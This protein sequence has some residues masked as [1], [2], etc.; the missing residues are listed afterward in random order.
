MRR[1]TSLPSDV[2]IANLTED[3]LAELEQALKI[4]EALSGPLPYMLAATSSAKSH[5]HLEYLNDIIV[6]AVELRLY[7]DG[8]GP[9]SVQNSEGLWVHPERG[10]EVIR[11]IEIDEP[12]RHGKSY[13]VSK[14]VP[15][16]FRTVYPERNVV[17]TSYEADFA[18]NWGVEAQQVIRDN[19]QFGAEIDRKHEAADDWKLKGHSGRMFTAGVGGPLTG[20]GF[21]LGIIDDPI[22]NQ[23]E[24]MSETIRTRHKNWWATTFFT[25]REPGAVIVIM[26]TRWHEDDL[27]GHIMETMPGKVFSVSIP[28]LA[29]DTTD[30]EGFSVDP[31]TGVRDILGRKPGEALWPQRFSAADL[32]AIK[33]AQGTLWFTAMYQGKPSIAEGNKFRRFEA[34]YELKDGVYTLY[35]PDGAAKTWHESQCIR[36]GAIDLAATENTDSDWSVFAIGDITPDHYLIIRYI[37]RERVESH[38]HTTW[39]EA[40]AVRFRPRWTMNEQKTFEL[41]L[42]QN[43]RRSGRWI[44]RKCKSKGDKVAKATPAVERVGEDRVFLPKEAAWLDPWIREHKAF[45]NGKHDDQVDTTWLLVESFDEMHAWVPTEP[46]DDSMVGKLDRYVEGKDQRRHD[47]P[48]LGWWG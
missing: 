25:R 47:H 18:R 7:T 26:A 14:H 31:D 40:I 11:I 2:E 29:W 22:K 39:F 37:K 16:W 1:S 4:D 20:K 3:E 24:A 13:F 45:P 15:A 21:H 41:Q 28:A 6:A 43:I 9:P 42:V 34:R 33:E 35:H 38:K 36:I 32:Q 10:D 19:P 5:A 46:E 48:D 27:S 17:V 8:P 12:P 44:M 30:E 23:D